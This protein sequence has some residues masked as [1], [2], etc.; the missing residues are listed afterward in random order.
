[1]KELRN[2]RIK[3]LCESEFGDLEMQEKGDLK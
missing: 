2:E 1:M 3:E